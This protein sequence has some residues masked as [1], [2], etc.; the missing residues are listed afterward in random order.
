VS[1][2]DLL[3][4]GSVTLRLSATCKR[5]A[6]SVISEM[7]ARTSGVRASVIF[8]ALMHR[9]A[10][11]STGVG[12]GV[13]VPHARVAGLATLRGIFLRLSTPIE[14]ESVDDRPV[15]LV[16]ALLA[17][18]ECGSEPLRAL[19]RIAR[20]LR[21]PDLR[22]QL[23]AATSAAAVRALLVQESRPSAA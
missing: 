7:A 20:L 5:Q 9:E 2:G 23:R 4:P 11:G 3:T 12:H 18:L 14:F 15:D 16:F 6:L 17:P 10:A 19:S 13:G 22:G 1:V 21:D 8:D